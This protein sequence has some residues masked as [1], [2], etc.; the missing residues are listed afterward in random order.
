M[1]YGMC[2]ML[3]LAILPK[4]KM[5]CE[6]SIPWVI[7]QHYMQVSCDILFNVFVVF[8]YNAA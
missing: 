6:K 8:M 2:G 7:M 3:V 1:V 4:I 5:T